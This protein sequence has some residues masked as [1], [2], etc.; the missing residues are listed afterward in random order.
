MA[1]TTAL[2]VTPAEVRYRLTSLTAVEISD[3]VLNS[4]SMI[5]MANAWANRILAENDTDIATI[6][7][8]QAALLKAAKI[9]VVCMRVVSD[10][11]LESFDVGPLH[12]KNVSA[13]DKAV[14]IAILDNEK[15]NLLDTADLCEKKMS[16]GSAGGD[17]YFPSGTDETNVD[18]IWAE[19]ENSDEPFRM[20]P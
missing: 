7:S 11:N 12:T 13:Q 6:T 10:A 20:F 2:N 8:D 14:M 16:I 9:A 4:A 3:T 5:L 15:K 18:Y 1:D 19:D 17:D